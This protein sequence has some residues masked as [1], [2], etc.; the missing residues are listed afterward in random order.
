MATTSFHPQAP[1]T[2]ALSIAYH[3]QAQFAVNA[4][5]IS[6]CIRVF[7]CRVVLLKLTRMVVG[8]SHVMPVA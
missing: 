1:A 8:V 3:A 2:D 6:F 4:P 7:A 5:L